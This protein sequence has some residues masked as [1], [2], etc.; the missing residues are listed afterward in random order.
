MPFL[1][2]LPTQGKLNYAITIAYQYLVNWTAH[3]KTVCQL[4]QPL[5]DNLLEMPKIRFLYNE[6]F[7]FQWFCLF[8]FMFLWLY[9]GNFIFKNLITGVVVNNIL[10]SLNEKRWEECEVRFSK[11]FLLSGSGGRYKVQPVFERY[12]FFLK[13]PLYPYRKNLKTLYVIDTSSCTLQT[14][15]PGTL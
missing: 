7:S 1:Y 5:P 9:M 11:I 14:S 10:Q 8:M 13:S 6:I 15:P 4:I 3:R 2:L 12:I